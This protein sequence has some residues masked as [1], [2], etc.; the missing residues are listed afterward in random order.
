AQFEKMLAYCESS[1]C[2]MVSLVRYFGDF[3]NARDRCG[4]CDFCAPTAVVSQTFRPPDDTELEQIGRILEA[5]AA[6]EY[7]TGTGRLHQSCFGDGSL[8]RRRFEELLAAMARSGLVD[9]A[10]ASFEKD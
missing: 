3:A 5:L 4:V 1:G 6:S 9:I 2:R 7:G 10:D 8:D